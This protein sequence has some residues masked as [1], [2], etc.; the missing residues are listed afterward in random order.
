MNP[1]TLQAYL[2]VIKEVS[3]PIYQAAYQRVLYTNIFSIVAAVLLIVVAAA[4]L[5]MTRP[6]YR[7]KSDAPGF[8]EWVQDE[9]TSFTG[10]VVSMVILC[11]ALPLLICSICNLYSIDYC[12]YDLV[13]RTLR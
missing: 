11:F 12:V 5:K 2:E 6:L 13:L 3:Q 8:T 1:E 4:V 10:I 9:K 7:N